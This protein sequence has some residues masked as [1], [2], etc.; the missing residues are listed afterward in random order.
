MLLFHFFCA[1]CIIYLLNVQLNFFIAQVKNA[2]FLLLLEK[3]I[4]FTFRQHRETKELQDE[5]EICSA[6]K[7]KFGGKLTFVSEIKRQ[8][9][10]KT[11][12]HV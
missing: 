11:E 3:P 2:L 9:T 10:D 6:E 12:K 8:L 7:D 1:T 5:G 4:N